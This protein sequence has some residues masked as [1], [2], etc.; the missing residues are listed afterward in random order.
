MRNFEQYAKAGA[1]KIARNS[2]YDMQVTDY[3]ALISKMQA[4]NASIYEVINDAFCA[5]VEAGA[6]IQAKKCAALDNERA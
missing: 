4:G 2:R 1:A 6:R 3:N 5:G